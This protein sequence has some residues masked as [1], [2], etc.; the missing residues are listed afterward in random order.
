MQMLYC[1]NF[2]S[3]IYRPETLECPSSNVITTRYKCKS[4]G[5]WMD[6]TRKYCCPDYVFI[7]GR[8]ELLLIHLFHLQLELCEWWIKMV[9]Q[10]VGVFTRI[11]IPAPWIC[12]NNS[13]QYTCN[14]WSALVLMDTNLIRKIKDWGLNLYASV[15]LLLLYRLPRKQ[16]C[17]KITKKNSD[18]ENISG[19]K[20][21]SPFWSFKQAKHFFLII[22]FDF[23][24]WRLINK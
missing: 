16:W 18:T 13:A 3:I 5:R 17:Q 23:R 22:F 14:E 11:T 4:K 24:H 21:S 19:W 8:W 2:I 9:A 6:C 1:I 10:I 15:S 12:A 20:V 7:A